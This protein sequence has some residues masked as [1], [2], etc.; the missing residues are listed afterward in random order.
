MAPY[1]YSKLEDEL[2]H[3]RLLLLRPGQFDDN[4][5]ATICHVSLADEPANVPLQR[6]SLCELKTTLP[7]D[8]QVYETV[9]GRYIFEQ[10]D[11]DLTSWVHP[12]P[13]IDFSAY[14]KVGEARYQNFRPRYEALSYTWGTTDNPTLLYIESED[15]KAPPSTLEIQE[16]LAIALKHLR[17]PEET[18][19]LWVDAV[20][21]NQNS[22]AER[23]TQVTRMTSIYKCASSVV[24]WLGPESSDSKLA[25]TTLDQIGSQTVLTKCV[26]RIRTPEAVHPDWFLSASTLPFGDDIW[27]AILGV[28]GRSWFDRVW[29]VQEIQ[30][31][32]STA[33]LQCGNDSIRWGRFRTAAWCIFRKRSTPYAPLT[34]RLAAIK[35]L[36]RTQMSTFVAYF[37]DLRP[38]S[39]L[40]SETM[41]MGSWVSHHQPF[42]VKFNPSMRQMWATCT[43]L[44]S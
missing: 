3:I 40:I 37:M 43:Q 10:P 22:I 24:A 38:D 9:E 17:F 44:P 31:A 6:L 21:I 35:M 34:H 1:Q 25:L 12:D 33:T 5:K 13:D 32:N 29:I 20:C 41:F 36:V 26:R 23:N 28:V 19:I 11:S 7:A 2:R 27:R 30:L 18:R 16:N 14:E 42:D 8:W 15:P 39:V 4:L